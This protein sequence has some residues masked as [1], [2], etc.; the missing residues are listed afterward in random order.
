MTCLLQTFLFHSN[1]LN[2]RFAVVIYFTLNKTGVRIRDMFLF[3]GHMRQKVTT[4][5]N[6]MKDKLRKMEVNVT[7]CKY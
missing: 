5:L 2:E 1:I 7:V 4:I 6:N 3:Y